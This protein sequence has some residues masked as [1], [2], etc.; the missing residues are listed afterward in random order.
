MMNCLIVH[1]TCLLSAALSVHA[2]QLPNL[3]IQSITAARSTTIL[4]A[5]HQS[6]LLEFFQKK[7][8]DNT[9]NSVEDFD[10]DLAA[11]IEDALLSA[12]FTGRLS[13]VTASPPDEQ[14][15]ISAAV[16]VSES[17]SS[18]E[19]SEKQILHQP[20]QTKAPKIDTTPPHTSLAQVMANQLNIDLSCVTPSNAK[21][22]TAADVEYHAWKMSQPPCTPEAL[23]I[24]HQSGLDL[25]AL[26]DDDDR[27]YVI[28]L[29]DVQLYEENCRSLRLI[30]Q[31]RRIGAP[32]NNVNPKTKQRTK[33]L[34]AI[35]ERMEKRMEVLAKKLGNVAG[36][37]AKTIKLQTSDVGLVNIEKKDESVIKSVEDVDAALAVEIQ[38]ALM[39]ADLVY[40]NNSNQIG[41]AK[42]LQSIEDV[43]E[44]ADEDAKPIPD[45]KSVQDFDATLAFEI[46][47]AITDSNSENN[48][49]G[50]MFE[51][52]KPPQSIYDI[53]SDANNDELGTIQSA[54]DIG[55]G[56]E[57]DL[58]TIHKS[59]T[60]AEIKEH[61]RAHGVKSCGKKSELAQRLHSLKILQSMTVE[62]LK[63]DLRE[64][65]LKVGGKKAEL[66]ERLIYAKENEKKTVGS[67]FFVH[68]Q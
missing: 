13:S 38:D 1:L 44:V 34:S 68:M 31:K 26:Y 23:T 2:W 4:K 63:Q 46:R 28:Q 55:S 39:N 40:E 7:N 21:K 61:L 33:K 64:Q 37:I 11:E 29:S 51:P 10:Q 15:T 53:E 62:Q 49:H 47:D 41:S 48:S 45:I 14:P 67:L 16:S 30:S 54:S 22:I 18:D 6:H 59:M 5:A 17:T 56:T 20:I 52:D 9:I 66:V 60:A 24:A 42:S 57:V 43:V 65:G 36:G 3:Q 8:K 27:E 58:Q 35:D 32:K 19:S 25:N 12:G 50:K